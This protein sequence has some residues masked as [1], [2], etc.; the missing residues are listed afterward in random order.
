M[1]SFKAYKQ[2]VQGDFPNLLEV[3]VVAL[4]YDEVVGHA[5]G[6]ST[7]TLQ[8]SDGTIIIYRYQDFSKIEMKPIAGVPKGFDETGNV[9]SIQ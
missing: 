8:F 9:V 2:E 7:F 6:S 5:F 4:E 3:E 1:F